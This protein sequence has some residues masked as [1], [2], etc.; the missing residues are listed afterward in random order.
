M[1]N[2][3]RG[4]VVLIVIGFLGLFIGLAAIGSA[5]NLITIPWLKFDSKVQ[6][7]RDIIT[8]TYDADNALYNYHWF[9][10][11]SEEIK[12]TDTKVNIALESLN[13]YQKY[14]PDKSKWTAIDKEEYNRLNTN[15]L[16]LKNYYNDL[17]ADYN[18]RAKSVDRAIFKDELPLFFD[19]K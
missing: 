7:N 6:M 11:K 14:W 19:V 5:L 8:K 3:E 4:G 18:A 9:K 12:A 13:T 16:G 2:K 17:I 15:Y 10:Q 1:K